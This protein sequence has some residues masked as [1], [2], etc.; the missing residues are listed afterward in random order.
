M[1]IENAKFLIQYANRCLLYA[2]PT[3]IYFTLCNFHFQLAHDAAVKK[4][5]K[6]RIGNAT[7]SC[8]NYTTNV[9]EEHNK[10]SCIS[11]LFDFDNK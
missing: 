3:Y 9:E 1:C 7:H 6:F 10:K 5:N 2:K 8:K 4:V 11:T